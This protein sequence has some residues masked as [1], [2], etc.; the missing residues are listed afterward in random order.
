MKRIESHL[1]T[2]LRAYCRDTQAVIT[3]ASLLE[4]TADFNTPADAQGAVTKFS[5]ALDCTIIAPATVR[6]TPK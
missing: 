6:F 3:R 4:F 5:S 1:M 2:K